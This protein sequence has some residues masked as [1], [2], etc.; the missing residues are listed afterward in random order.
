MAVEDR[1]QAPSCG[2]SGA[3][4]GQWAGAAP[5][6][7]GPARGGQVDSAVPLLPRPPP[8]PEWAGSLL[9]ESS[10]QPLCGAVGKSRASLS[11]PLKGQDYLSRQD[12][13]SRTPPPSSGG[14]RGPTT[15][16]CQPSPRPQVPGPGRGPGVERPSD[17]LLPAPHSPAAQTRNW[18]PMPCGLSGSPHP[19]R[20]SG[21]PGPRPSGTWSVGGLAWG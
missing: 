11:Q 7:A 3:R 10:W 5:G 13:L 8:G 6:D 4:S 21:G 14:G 15:G 12:A 20:P 17:P 2:G 18:F 19:S 9:W 1:F 16:S